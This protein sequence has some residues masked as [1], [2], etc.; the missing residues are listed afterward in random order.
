MCGDIF[1]VMEEPRSYYDWKVRLHRK[2]Q[3]ERR[4]ES[5]R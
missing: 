1:S 5:I 4:K 3:K 2:K